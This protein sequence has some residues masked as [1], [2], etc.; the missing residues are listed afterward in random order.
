MQ[1]FN[2]KEYLRQV[3][4]EAPG[5]PDGCLSAPKGGNES[6]L[7]GFS[8]SISFPTTLNEN[9]QQNAVLTNNQAGLVAL[10]IALASWPRSLA[11]GRTRIVRQQRFKCVA[12]P[13]NRSA[14]PI[15]N[16]PKRA[17]S[18]AHQLSRSIQVIQV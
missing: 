6:S 16:S 1:P 17:S 7:S 3:N 9:Q 8:L 14:Q 2:K 11:R 15:A 5:F 18:K 4:D 12:T 10:L 13:G